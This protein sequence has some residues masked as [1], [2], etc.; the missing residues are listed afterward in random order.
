MLIAACDLAAGPQDLGLAWQLPATSS[1]R[2]GTKG[3]MRRSCL[4]ASVNEKCGAQLR[5]TEN[6]WCPQQWKQT[7]THNTKP[8]MNAFHFAVAIE[9]KPAT[10]EN[11][12]FSMIVPYRNLWLCWNLCVSD[13]DDRSVI[14]VCLSLPR[15]K[16]EVWQGT[17][18]SNPLYQRQCRWLVLLLA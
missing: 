11:V 3:R 14:C 5:I 4:N 12:V 8:E 17:A 7:H 1:S 6:V 15:L 18:F 2:T 9:G 10:R 16:G 13:V